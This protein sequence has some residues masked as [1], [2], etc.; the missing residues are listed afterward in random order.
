MQLLLSALLLGC[1]DSRTLV[2]HRTEC[3]IDTL[4]VADDQPID[5]L[6]VT[7]GDVVT[8]VEGTFSFAAAYA[9]GTPVTGGGT[10]TRGLGSAI[11]T[12][13]TVE[14]WTTT[15]GTGPTAQSGGLINDGQ[16]EC[17]TG[18]AVP[19]EV[20]FATDDGVVVF[21]TSALASPSITRAD[22]VADFFHIEG[23]VAADSTEA[24]PTPSE[25]GA[26]PGFSLQ[27]TPDAFDWVSVW[28]SGTAY[29]QI[30]EGP[31]S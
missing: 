24:I 7:G 26:L 5:G 2:H 17:E 11:A 18:L 4:E 3:A 12:I 8:A 1:S 14:Q 13:A 28:F 9:D 30:L 16:G 27:W 15:T 23:D 25:P 31:A 29:E 20:E 21:S 19:V 6:S 10:V 22:G